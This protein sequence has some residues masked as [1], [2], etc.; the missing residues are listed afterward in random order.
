MLS[1]EN[2]KIRVPASTSNL[3][4]GFDTVGLALKIYSTITIGHSKTGLEITS[5]GEGADELNRP[6]DSLFFKAMSKA[7]DTW[8]ES[9]KNLSIHIE[10]N[11][12]ISRGLGGSAT[13]IIAGILL[14]AEVCGRNLS[15]GE[16]LA[17]ALP[18][19]NYHPDNITPALV[20][21]L[22]V[23]KV[24][25]GKVHFLKMPFPPELKCII[26]IPDKRLE[27]QLARKIL[28]D[29]VPF[30]DAV[31]NLQ[32]LSFLL[33][34]FATGTL[35]TLSIAMQDRL[36]QP[37]RSSLFPEMKDICNA[38]LK[39]GALGA[40]LS[41]S[42]TSII[43]FALKNTQVVVQAMQKTLEKNHLVGK[44]IVTGVDFEGAQIF[45]KND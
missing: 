17:L 11:V 15:S 42:G 40:A 31:F 36:H 3:G 23:S 32:S 26:S 19:E 37:Y 18:L 10:N 12:P 14:A 1:N 8:G 27:T 44:T 21:G 33:G 7:F 4:P 6:E 28:P 45:S 25:E 38:A 41:G 9:H 5:S 24:E 13:A 34:S 20:G 22:T 43:A 39:A 16:I 30:K 29:K 35:E 2:I